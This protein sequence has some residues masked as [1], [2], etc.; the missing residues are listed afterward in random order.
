MTMN[1]WYTIYLAET[2]RRQQDIKTAEMYRLAKQSPSAHASLRVHQRL[3]LALGSKLV[4]WGTRLQ[5]RYEDLS[6][7][8]LRDYAS[9]SPC[10]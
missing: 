9:E 7:T 1:D 10:G 6:T 4:Q 3:F 5:S 8:S 2:R